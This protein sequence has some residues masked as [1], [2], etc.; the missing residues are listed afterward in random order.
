MR[1]ASRCRSGA[2]QEWLFD[3]SALLILP[4][5]FGQLTALRVTLQEWPFDLSL[6]L[7]LSERCDQ[8]TVLRVA[9]QE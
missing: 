9:P 6:L 2:Q 4:G 3:L 8:L 1:C 5:S 7:S